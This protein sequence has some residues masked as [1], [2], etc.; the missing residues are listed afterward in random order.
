MKSTIVRYAGAVRW[1]AVAAMVP[2]LAGCMT[3][4]KAA[5]KGDLI[6]VKAF[7]L[8]GTDVDSR[9]AYGRTPLMYMVSDPESARYLVGQGADVNARDDLG[10]TPLM[11]AAWVG[12]LDVVKFLVEKGADLNA[13]SD[14]GE[15][16][17]MRAVRNLDVVKHLVEQGADVNAKDHKGETVLLKASVSGRLRVVQYLQKKGAAVEGSKTEGTAR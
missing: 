1:L 17:L 15:T 10:E 8:K 6:G 14:C 9:D 2:I 11:K 7:L 13:Q 16:P 12:N 4:H 3:I 5:N